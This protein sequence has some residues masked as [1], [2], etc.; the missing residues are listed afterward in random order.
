MEE[1][2]GESALTSAL[3]IT[4]GGGGFSVHHPE[5]SQAGRH[6]ETLHVVQAASWAQGK[7]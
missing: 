7:F 2:E 6:R 5:Q 4:V 3:V 1:G